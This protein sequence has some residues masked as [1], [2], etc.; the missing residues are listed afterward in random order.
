[1]LS[2][3]LTMDYTDKTRLEDVNS[4]LAWGGVMQCLHQ[5]NQFDVINFSDEAQHIIN[6]IGCLFLGIISLIVKSSPTV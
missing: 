1:M 4:F 6:H 3:L 2:N 5:N